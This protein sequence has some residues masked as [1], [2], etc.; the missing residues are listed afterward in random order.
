MDKTKKELLKNIVYKFAELAKITNTQM[1]DN[2]V[3]KL[4][5]LDTND[6]IDTI[7]VSL[8]SLLSCSLKNNYNL[9]LITAVCCST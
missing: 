9:S 7:L 3:E 8:N 2:L 5:N 1:R 6:S 4:L